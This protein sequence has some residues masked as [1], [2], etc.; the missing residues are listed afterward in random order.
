MDSLLAT[1]R[2]L[3]LRR[4]VM[5]IGAT[6]LALGGVLA[7]GQ[8]A[9]RPGMALLYSGLEPSAAGEV[10]GALEQMGVP[11]ELAGNAIRVAEAERDRVRLALA[12]DGM[13]QQGQAGYE[14]L[15][16]ISGFSTTTDMFNAAFWRAKEGEL[17][18][19]IAASPA[20]RA[21]RVHI[22]PPG[23]QGF[24]REPAPPSASV[25]VTRAGGVLP[26][27]AASGFRYL[28]ALAVP[29]LAPEQ[30]AVI[31][32]ASGV[33]LAPGS[34]TPAIALSGAA[35]AR[36]EKLREEIEALL[37]ARVGA[38]KARVSVSVELERT[39]ETLSER[40]LDPDSR[41]VVHSDTEEIA[42]ESRGGDP[43]VTVASNLPDGE[44]AAGGERSATRTESR[45]RSNFDY[46]ETRRERITSPGSVRR[47]SVAVLVDGIRTARDDGTTD[48]QPRP[49]EE[50]E[51][52]RALVRAAVGFDE[53]RGD[54]VTVES[55][56]FQPPAELG[57]LAESG[58]AERFFERN[59]FAILQMLVLAAVVLV[60]V[61]TV[62][63]PLL[64]RPRQPEY[65]LLAEGEDAGAIPLAQDGD[66]GAAVALDG[67]AASA[68]G[69]EDALFNLP[70]RETLR[71][72][73]N[74]F[75]EQSASTLRDWLDHGDEEAA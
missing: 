26:V 6:L 54:V 43:S 44:G 51:A 8:F 67:P 9:A 28:V 40:R 13:P 18:R 62:L 5:L 19:T 47:L 20:V 59:A 57:T 64:L 1:W 12:R 73:V 37:A 27:Q 29:G 11:Y 10:V 41:V 17:A 53:A 61:F 36:E 34:E 23:R 48:W 58:A 68:E 75:P 32:S 45:E 49:E 15:D 46:D 66:S 22:A 30:V 24:A 21:A 42:D 25:T 52:L 16:G 72:A 31:D 69:F 3:D 55:M 7:I 65:P 39:A 2:A 70:D 74:Q 33:I 14:L 38:D 71:A 56:A 50:L 35:A 63:R 60:I 4:R